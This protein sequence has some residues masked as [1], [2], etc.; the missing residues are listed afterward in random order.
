METATLIPAIEAIGLDL[1]SRTIEYDESDAILY[2]LAV[3]A[4]ATELEL[5]FERD[6]RVL[7]TFALPHGLWASDILGDRGFFSRS[8]A[9]H[10]YQRFERLGDLPPRG[11]FEQQARVSAVWDKGSAAIFEIEVSCALFRATYAIF[12]PGCGGFGGDR[13]PSARRSQQTAPSRRLQ[14]ATSPDQ[15]ALYRLTGDRHLIHI[16]PEAAR[17]IGAPRPILHGLC[18]LGFAARELAGL[19]GRRPWELSALE[20]RFTAAVLPGDLLDIDAW[21]AEADGAVPFA[22][23]VAGNVVLDGG[24]VRF[25]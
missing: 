15:A 14:V 8:T 23:S 11:R 10:G 19:Q 6:L 22:V 9:V 16:D 25:R 5:V 3:G 2:A 20:A 24:L 7:P 18:T 12:A 1:G 21:P 13:G 4:P 17:V